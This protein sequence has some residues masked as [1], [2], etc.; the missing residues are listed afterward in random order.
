MVSATVIAVM[1]KQKKGCFKKAAGA[2]GDMPIK[3]SKDNKVAQD[4]EFAG[5][6]LD[7]QR[8]SLKQMSKMIKADESADLED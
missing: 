6:S 7:K 4:I 3:P 5:Q 8:K 1:Y 2:Q